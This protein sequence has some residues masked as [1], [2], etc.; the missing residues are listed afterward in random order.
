MKANKHQL[1][2]AI[3]K[4][5]AE[6]GD[7]HEVFAITR[8]VL[9]DFGKEQNENMARLVYQSS[10]SATKNS[11]FRAGFEKLAKER[12]KV[13]HAVNLARS[14]FGFQRYAL[15][16]LGVWSAPM[17]VL[18]GSKTWQACHTPEEVAGLLKKDEEQKKLLL[19]WGRVLTHGDEGAAAAALVTPELLA[20]VRKSILAV[21]AALRK[22]GKLLDKLVE[23]QDGEGVEWAVKAYEAMVNGGK[24]G[25][26]LRGVSD[27][28]KAGIN[29]AFFA[30][31]YAESD[32]LRHIASG[33]GPAWHLL[34]KADGEKDIEFEKGQRQELRADEGAGQEDYAG[35]PDIIVRAANG[36]EV[37]LGNNPGAS[38]LMSILAGIASDHASK[39]EDMLA[40]SRAMFDCLS[41]GVKEQDFVFTSFDELKLAI[42]ARLAEG[43]K[44]RAEAKARN[45]ALERA[46]IAVEAAADMD[47]VSRRVFLKSL[48][49]LPL[50]DAIE[51]LRVERKAKIEGDARRAAQAEKEAAEAAAAAAKEAAYAA[52]AA[53]AAEWAAGKEARDAERAKQARKEARAFKDQFKVDTKEV[54]VELADR[55]IPSVAY[56]R[57]LLAKE[58][59]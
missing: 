23:F 40:V 9:A 50:A 17:K 57:E 18:T 33:H 48:G 54:V 45:K 13:L 27:T 46:L 6:T 44:E 59:K 34:N 35:A 28:I 32:P 8:A 26:V 56:Y 29:A 15:D 53:R 58:V 16:E 1:T 51:A 21:G 52:T 5:V 49:D 38:E 30:Q 10:L 7:T 31:R 41:C 43:V 36:K 25:D 22:K 37:N 4:A 20:E 12:D 11:T 55:E 39:A 47:A 24:P 2:A 3:T 42:D 14:V 19:A